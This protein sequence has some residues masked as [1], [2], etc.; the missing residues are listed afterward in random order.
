[1]QLFES[2][3]LSIAPHGVRVTWHLDSVEITFVH[4][5]PGRLIISIFM[6]AVGS[7][8]LCA[9]IY[10]VFRKELM[11]VL[12]VSMV[13]A[14]AAGLG[15]FVWGVND[16]RGSTSARIYANGVLVISL[17]G[18]LGE[19]KMHFLADSTRLRV[20]KE[21]FEKHYLYVEAAEV[22]YSSN[23]LSD[24]H[25]LWFAEVLKDWQGRYG[26][27]GR[28]GIGSSLPQW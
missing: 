3:Y 28:M 6:M 5:D 11:G 20:Q 14:Y 25:A 1:M 12:I 8:L 16:M 17:R 9:V 23:G 24:Q 21:K 15:L 27:N 26:H 2:Y 18:P 10:S 19:K 7:G 13:L 4:N 22:T